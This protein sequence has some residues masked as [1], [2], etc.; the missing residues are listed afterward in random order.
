MAND[1]SIANQT[2]LS[3]LPSNELACGAGPAIFGR[4]VEGQADKVLWLHGY[5]L[6][7]SS[8]GNLWQRLPGWQHIGI[9][10]PGHGRSAPIDASLSLD[11]IGRRLAEFCK[12]ENIEHLV[13]L[14]FGTVTALQIA[15][16]APNHF[17]SI[18]LAGPTIAGGPQDPDVQ[19]AYMDLFMHYMQGE[20]GEALRK[21]WMACIAWKGVDTVPGLE[22]ALGELVANHRWAELEGFIIRRV[23]MPEQSLQQ[24]AQIASPTLLIFGDHEL[25][26]FVQ[27]AET[28]AQTL[29]HSS[30]LVLKNTHHLCLLQSPDQAA[31]A[32]SEHLQ[33]FARCTDRIASR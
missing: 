22:E 31:P 18:V 21:I 14:S 26:A 32:I 12:R 2:L 25:G 15:I 23:F 27:C 6:D 4:V 28:L 20:R 24:I 9:D 16:E 19:A 30:T 17:R 11:G 1:G 33:Q 10:F 29:E 7:S 8:W 5:T 13:A 3:P